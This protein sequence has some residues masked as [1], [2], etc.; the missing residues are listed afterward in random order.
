MESSLRGGD[1]RECAVADMKVEQNEMTLPG[2]SPRS[3]RYRVGTLWVIVGV[4]ALLIG[5]FSGLVMSSVG[6]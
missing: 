3:S 1:A 5:L 2:E 4:L 6:S